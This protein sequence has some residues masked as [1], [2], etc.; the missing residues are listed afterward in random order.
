MITS[1]GMN[2]DSSDGFELNSSLRA[3]KSGAAASGTL[4]SFSRDLQGK[5]SSTIS[6]TASDGATAIYS[7]CRAASREEGGWIETAKSGSPNVCGASG[8][9]IDDDFTGKVA[10]IVKNMRENTDMYLL[11]RIPDTR[12]GRRDGSSFMVVREGVTTASVLNVSSR[13][14]G[15]RRRSNTGRG[16][17]RQ[18]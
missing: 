1:G 3:R 17:P 2:D 5:V 4:D 12:F 18:T 10:M 9:R 13:R 15:T 6:P 16:S 11:V 7:S 8:G 14:I